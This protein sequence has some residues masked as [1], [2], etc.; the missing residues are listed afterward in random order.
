MLEIKTT[1][2]EMKNKNASD[3]FISR[4]GMAEERI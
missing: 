3:G 4:P 2:T 1:G